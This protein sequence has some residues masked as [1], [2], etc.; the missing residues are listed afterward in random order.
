MLAGLVA[1]AIQ[2]APLGGLTAI[3]PGRIVTLPIAMLFGPWFGLL[4]ALV[5]GIPYFVDSPAMMAVFGIEAWLIGTFEKR[6]RSS[7]VAGALVWVSAALALLLFPALFGFKALQATLVPLALQRALSGMSAVVVAELVSVAISSRWPMVRERSEARGLRTFSFHAFVLAAVAPAL[8]LSTGTVLVIGARQMGEGGARLRDS[9]MVLSDHIDEYLAGQRRAVESLAATLSVIGDDPKRR[10]QILGEYV[11]IQTGFEALRIVSIKGDVIASAPPLPNLTRLS[12]KDRAFFTGPVSTHKS[13]ISDVTLGRLRPVTI[14]AVSAPLFSAPDQVSGVTYGVLD[15]SNFRHFVEQ[16]QSSP[17]ATVVILDHLDRVIYTSERSPFTLRQD[18]SG[19]ELVHAAARQSEN[20]YDY[21]PKV[22]GA[23]NATQAVGTGVVDLADWKVFV[24]QPR[25]SMR[26][27]APEYYVLTLALI[28]LAL[29]GGILVARSFSDAVT[30]PLE[31]LT[32]VVRSVSAAGTPVQV[33]LVP[34]VPAEIATLVK[35][36]NGMQSRLADSYGQ[37]E[38]AVA[39]RDDLNRDLRELTTTLDRK[40]RERTEELATAKSAAEEA[41][42]A[43]SEFLANMSHEIRTPMN[44]IIGMTDLAL[45]TELT[46]EQRDYLQMVK[47]SADSLLTVL[48][49]I[50]DF[51]KIE[52]GS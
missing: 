32:S 7:L 28:A 21:T 37:L 20:V 38:K 49:D 46:A 26:L 43:K 1:L 10:E 35:N 29:G 36:I 31:Q 52:A 24:T 16:Y 39:D 9:A 48:N 42:R 25:L 8:V 40:V 17:D 22:A 2:R 12:I 6:G 51:S 27:Q 45:D 47:G 41:N 4:A 3:W 23:G 30:Q 11:R 5:G 18:L 15:L 14:V 44:G 19:D 34:H 13:T 50:L 33:P